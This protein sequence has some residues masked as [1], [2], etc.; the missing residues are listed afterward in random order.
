MGR[1]G[2]ALVARA[3]QVDA[4]A[5]SAAAVGAARELTRLAYP[6]PPAEAVAILAGAMARA[7]GG[8]RLGGAVGALPPREALA[9]VVLARAV[10]RA[11]VG[12]CLESAVVS[13]VAGRADALARDAVPSVEAAVRAALL[14]A[15]EARPAFGAMA[16][17]VLAV[18][19]RGAGVANPARVDRAVVAC[20][21]QARGAARSGEGR[22]ELGCTE[23]C[24]TTH[25]DAAGRGTRELRHVHVWL[26][27]E[28]RLADAHAVG[29]LAVVRALVEAVQLG[30]LLERQAGQQEAEQEAAAGQHGQR[31]RSALLFWQRAQQEKT[32]NEPVSGGGREEFGDFSE[33]RR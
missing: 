14:T 5:V 28:G 15:V 24:P 7:A 6:A 3:L 19:V 31:G 20:G 10:A 17:K 22:S 1:A 13:K 33:G 27:G 12:T 9:R 32:V 16:R 2:P 30:R 23:P 21:P 26:T 18:A 8:A 25:G 29:A 4:A 11:V